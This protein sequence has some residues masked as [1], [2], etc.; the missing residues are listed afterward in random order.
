MR[1]RVRVWRVCAR[2]WAESVVVSAARQIVSWDVGRG[3]SVEMCVELRLADANFRAASAVSV[4]EP[5]VGSRPS[6]A[7]RTPPEESR[8]DSAREISGGFRPLYYI[9]YVLI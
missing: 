2:G 5:T 7:G 8:A 9:K 3:P 1:G 6:E 4:L